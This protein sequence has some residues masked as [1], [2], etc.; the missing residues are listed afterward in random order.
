VGVDDGGT[1]EIAKRSRGTPRVANRL[2]R[3]IRDF[4]HVKRADAIDRRVA[5]AALVELARDADVLLA[6]ASFVDAVP[7][8]ERRTLSS[9]RD[10]GRQAAEAGVG[11]L[12]LTHLLPGTER[13]GSAAAARSAFGGPIR[14][15]RPGLRLAIG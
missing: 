6:E 15:A 12:V 10:V 5:D 2:L 14:V 4:A 7:G 9:A 11:T 3:R 13:R 1:R 8:D